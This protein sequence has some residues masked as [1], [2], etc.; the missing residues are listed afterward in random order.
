MQ[1]SRRHD[2]LALLVVALTALCVVLASGAAAL[3]SGEYL[4]SHNW[5]AAEGLLPRE[6]LDAVQAAPGELWGWAGGAV[7]LAINWNLDRATTAGIVA[8]KNVPADSRIPVPPEKFSLQHLM[9]R[10]R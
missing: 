10:G 1:E 7:A 3:E 8:G 6:F 4:D 5:S 2:F 9:R